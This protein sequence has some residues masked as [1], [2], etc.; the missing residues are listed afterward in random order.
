MTDDMG[1]GRVNTAGRYQ[2]R[3]IVRY[4]ITDVAPEELPYLDGLCRFDDKT[5]LR[6]LKRGDRSDEP[7]GFGLGDI[8]TLLTPIV[9]LALEETARRAADAAVDGAVRR[10]RAGLRRILHRPKEPLTLPP[11]TPE[12]LAD[13]RRR[14]LEVGMRH[15]LDLPAAERIADAVV[16]HS[17]LRDLD[18][19]PSPAGGEAGQAEDDGTGGLPA[20]HA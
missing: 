4:V 16:V 17:A 9:W 13:L 10:G 18:Q 14:V 1:T 20:P 11:L 3:D 19:P 6:R 5:I 15:G 8:V 7:L 2:L 12:Q